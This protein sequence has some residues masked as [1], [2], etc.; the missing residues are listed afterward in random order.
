M[1]R[2]T[3][4]ISGPDPTYD[5]NPTQPNLTHLFTLLRNKKFLD[6]GSDASQTRTWT[7]CD[8]ARTD[9]TYRWIQPMSISSKA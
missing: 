1:R 8:P 5:S 3:I 6:N 7:L 2:P 4:E 9:R